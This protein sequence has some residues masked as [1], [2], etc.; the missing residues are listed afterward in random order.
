MSCVSCVPKV[1]LHFFSLPVLC[2][3]STTSQT[4]YLSRHYEEHERQRAEIQHVK[5]KNKTKTHRASALGRFKSASASQN[6]MENLSDEAKDV[7]D[8][9]PYDHPSP[10]GLMVAF[11]NPLV[12]YEYSSNSVIV[13]SKPGPTGRFAPQLRRCCLPLHSFELVMNWNSTSCY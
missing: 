5:S 13:S 12:Q 9:H 4:K 2:T 1:G 7:F 10:Y 3:P 8:K 11:V 6:H